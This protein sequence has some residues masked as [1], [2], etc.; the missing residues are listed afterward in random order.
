[1]FVFAHEVFRSSG[2]VDLPIDAAVEIGSLKVDFPM[3]ALRMLT[4][5][6]LLAETISTTSVRVVQ[7]EKWRSGEVEKWRSG[8]GCPTGAAPVL[9]VAPARRHHRYHYF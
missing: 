2:L 1:M 3:L 6:H 4:S 5:L 9:P 7:V 8:A